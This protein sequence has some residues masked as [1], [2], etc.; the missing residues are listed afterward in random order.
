M[1]LALAS[2]SLAKVRVLSIQT[3]K[4]IFFDSI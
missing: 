3:Y 2:A 1:H 4:T